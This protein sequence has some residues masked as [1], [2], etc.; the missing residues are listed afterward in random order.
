MINIR[1]E[2][3]IQGIDL[4]SLKKSLDA[5]EHHATYRLDDHEGRIRALEIEITPKQPLKPPSQ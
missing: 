2:Q 3:K 5:H 4:E 1:A